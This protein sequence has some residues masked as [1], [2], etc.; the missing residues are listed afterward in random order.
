MTRLAGWLGID[1]V[2]F[3]VFG[4]G[5][6]ALMIVVGWQLAGEDDPVQA[7]LFQSETLLDDAPIADIA[8]TISNATTGDGLTEPTATVREEDGPVYV[9]IP[10]AT[11]IQTLEPETVAGVAV[12]DWVIVG[13]IDDNVNSYIVQGVVVVADAEVAR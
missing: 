4:A 1:P 6:L 11:I 9:S 13:G 3:T 5:L 2:I 8:G 12:G 10:G 7:R